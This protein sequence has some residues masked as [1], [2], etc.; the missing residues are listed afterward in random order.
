MSEAD[1]IHARVRNF[2][3]ITASLI[4]V[5][6]LRSS[7]LDRKRIHPICDLGINHPAYLSNR[8]K[9]DSQCEKLLFNI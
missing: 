3:L 8:K 2:V 9:T 5:C 7:M 6:I 1:G 4:Y